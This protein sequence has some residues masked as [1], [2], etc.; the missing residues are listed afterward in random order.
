MGHFLRFAVLIAFGVLLLMDVVAV[1]P[2][3]KNDD[4]HEFTVYVMPTLHPLSWESPSALY[5]TMRKCYIKTIGVKDNYLLGHVAVGFNTSLLP[6]TLLIAQTSGEL[7]EKLDLIF[8]YKVGYAIMGAALQGRIESHEELRHK[9]DVYAKR[10]K[11]AFIR[12]KVSKSAAKRMLDFVTEYSAKMNEH[13]APSDFY[14]G[15]FW[16]RYHQEG[17]GCSAFGMA[18]L[19]LVNLLPDEHIKE[20]ELNVNIPMKLIG[21]K[22]NKGKKVKYSTIRK[23]DSWYIGE[24]E[25]NVDY[26][27][28]SVYEPSIMFDWIMEKRDKQDKTYLPIEEN[29]VPGLVFDATQIDFDKDEPFFTERSEPNIFIEHYK[30][31]IKLAPDSVRMMK[32]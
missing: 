10:N 22:F 27:P 16:P 19:D 8:K 18:L 12:Y 3:R 29:G 24:G 31:R 2:E 32:K 4:I 1:D 23:T 9:L 6:D 11:L 25:A 5:K 28:Y 30:K 13:Y 21:G 14:G 20:W 26:V 15:A 17:A 7:K